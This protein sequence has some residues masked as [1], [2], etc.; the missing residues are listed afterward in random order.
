MN[1][2]VAKKTLLVTVHSN[3]MK[4]IEMNREIQKQ[5]R[6]GDVSESKEEEKDVIDKVE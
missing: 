2:S 4:Q 1:S 5:I 3:C 6:V